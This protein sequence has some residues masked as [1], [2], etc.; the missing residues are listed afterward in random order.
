VATGSSPVHLEVWLDG[1][2]RIS[3][4]DSSSSRITG[5]IPGMENYNAGVKYDSFAVYKR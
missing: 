3:Y 4:D 2:R 1:T 5:G